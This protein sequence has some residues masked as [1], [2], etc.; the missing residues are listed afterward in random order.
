[1]ERKGAVD[2]RARIDPACHAR[3]ESRLKAAASRT[4]HCDFIHHDRREIDFSRRSRCALQYDLSARPH[5]F[6]RAAKT[7][8]A[9][10]AIDRHVEFVPQRILFRSLEAEL[11]QPR[12]LFPMMSRDNRQILLAL[13]RERDNRA[14]PAVAHDDDSLIAR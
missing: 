10:A 7:G 5:E 11:S 9:S 14:E 6:Y 13:E 8:L 12:E 1:V 4:D 3:V 2:Q